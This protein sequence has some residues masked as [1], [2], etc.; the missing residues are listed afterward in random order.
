MNVLAFD[1]CFG[2]C[3]VA[4][5]VDLGLPTERLEEFFEPRNVGHAESLV[6]MIKSAMSG[7]CIDFADLDRIAV[8]HGPGFPEGTRLG[9]AT[10]RALHLRTGVPLVSASSL[11]VMAEEVSDGLGD[12]RGDRPLGVAVAASPEVEP[13][14]REPTARVYVQWFA[15]GGLSPL[16]PPR[17]VSPAEAAALVEAPHVLLVGSGAEAVAA[18]VRRSGRRAEARLPRQQVDACALAFLARQLDLADALVEPM[19]LGADAANAQSTPPGR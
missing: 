18:A 11:A 2:A 7:A 17:L 8:T 13:D 5:G 1:T 16:G 10:A 12:A 3:S 15:R 14:V 19:L 6:P 9:V 4:V